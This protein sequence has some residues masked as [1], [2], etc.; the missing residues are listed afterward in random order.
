MSGPAQPTRSPIPTKGSFAVT[1]ST[2][3]PRPT[4]AML[5]RALR[6]ISSMLIT[7]RA[8]LVQVWHSE[9]GG[10]LR[11]GQ[12]VVR[13]NVTDFPDERDTILKAMDHSGPHLWVGASGMHYREWRGVL[14]TMDVVVSERTFGERPVTRVEVE[15]APPA[16][17]P[18][19]VAAPTEHR[20]E[21]GNSGPGGPLPR[22]PADRDDMMM[23]ILTGTGPWPPAAIDVPREPGQ[24]T[25]AL[26]AKYAGIPGVTVVPG[27]PQP[28]A[29][30]AAEAA[31][32]W[33][34]FA[35]AKAVHEL[36]PRGPFPD[37]TEAL[38]AVNCW[39]G[40]DM[41]EPVD[42]LDV[43][44]QLVEPGAPPVPPEVAQRQARGRVRNFLPS[45]VRATTR[46]ARGNAR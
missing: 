14:L 43:A 44:G 34:R 15:Q 1:E 17:D 2:S 9:Y 16:R 19:G 24:S 7:A 30:T 8:E 12:T 18:A 32:A 27:N 33:R 42:A 4:P 11:V 23:T 35:M 26:Q 37:L 36:S 41:L 38:T 31:A 25:A 10:P 22:P 39:H 20:I 28:E 45:F 29:G 46:P 3:T 5:A 6:L 21:P 13:L 40:R